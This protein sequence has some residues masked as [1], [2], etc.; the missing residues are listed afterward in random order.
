MCRPYTV[1]SLNLHIIRFHVNST[2]SKPYLFHEK[3]EEGSKSPI[4]QWGI[5]FFQQNRTIHAIKLSNHSVCLGNQDQEKSSYTQLP[6]SL[7]DEDT[8]ESFVLEILQL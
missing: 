3:E 6:E 1:G 7:S 5:F 2:L 4:S 8:N